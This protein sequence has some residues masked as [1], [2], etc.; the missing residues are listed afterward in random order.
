M[1]E[2]T[3][4]S[5]QIDLDSNPITNMTWMEDFWADQLL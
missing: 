1:T 5:D 4:P 2:R 3:R